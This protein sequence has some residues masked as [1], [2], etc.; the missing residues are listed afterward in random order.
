M[1]SLEMVNTVNKNDQIVGQ[2]DRRDI[3]GDF[4]NVRFVAAF[5]RNQLGQLWIPTRR[6]DKSR[7]PGGLDFAMGGAVEA[8]ESYE[9]SAIREIR[10]E[11]GWNLTYQDLNEI[12]Y[13]SPHKFPIACFL[14][15]YELQREAEPAEIEDEYSGGRWYGVEEL[16]AG[17]KTNRAPHKPDLLPVVRL[18]YGALQDLDRQK[19][20]P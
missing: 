12:A 5:I 11:L 6:L 7:W 8:G 15:V 18:C 16:I 2:S 13:L 4:V 20:R 17:L 9:Q 10:E 1:Q 3:P 14:K 19:F